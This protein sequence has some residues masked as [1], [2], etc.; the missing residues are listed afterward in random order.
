MPLNQLQQ[1][2]LK[3]WM[4]SKAIVQCPAC[5]EDRWLFA[6]AAYLRALLEAGEADLIEAKGVVKISCGNC[7][8]VALFDAETL[9]IRGA[10]ANS[11]NL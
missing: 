6:E 8:Y 1:Q 11:R 2:T 9:G 7:G 5:G 3:D 10:W 4:R